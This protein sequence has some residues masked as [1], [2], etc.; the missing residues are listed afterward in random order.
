MRWAALSQ[1]AT[2]LMHT[3]R[4]LHGGAL[5]CAPLPLPPPTPPPH[6]NTHAHTSESM[7]WMMLD[8]PASPLSSRI[9]S[10]KPEAASASRPCGDRR[11][12]GSAGA[13]RASGQKAGRRERA[14][15]TLP[16]YSMKKKQQKKSQNWAAFQPGLQVH[17]RL[18]TQQ[19]GRAPP[20]ACDTAPAPSPHC[21]ARPAPP[22]PAGGC[23]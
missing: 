10:R 17:S 7:S 19:Q 23:A 1:R 8:L 12:A 21:S 16:A 3:A 4:T 22:A 18:H 6:S 13:G 2:A 11:A 14:A 15:H 9:S 20:A 5:P